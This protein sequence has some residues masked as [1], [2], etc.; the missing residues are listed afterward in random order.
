MGV[1]F[2]SLNRPV[3]AAVIATMTAALA[4]AAAAVAQD[5]SPAGSVTTA[6]GAP[7]PTVTCSSQPGER[8]HCP[9]DTSAGVLLARTT[10]T[11]ACLLGK[12]WGYDDAGIW[13]MDGCGGEFVVSQAAPQ[14]VPAPAAVPAAG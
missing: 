2:R 10:G 8:R 14:V 6:A 12:S 4:A 11:A 9:A 1:L 3:R 5:Q 7:I 13:V